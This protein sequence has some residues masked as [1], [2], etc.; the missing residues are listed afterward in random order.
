MRS[1]AARSPPEIFCPSCDGVPLGNQVRKEVPTAP[2]S[3][4]SQVLE[5]PTVRT[6]SA[7]SG[8]RRSCAS[9]PPTDVSEEPQNADGQGLLPLPTEETLQRRAQSDRA[10]TEIAK[11]LLRGYA[12][13]AEECPNLTCFSVPLVRPPKT[14]DGAPSPNRECVV[15]RSVFTFGPDGSLV[16]VVTHRVSEIRANAQLPVPTLDSTI[17]P[18]SRPAEKWMPPHASRVT[19][20]STEPSMPSIAHSTLPPSDSLNKTVATLELSLTALASRL[21]ELSSPASSVRGGLNTTAILEVSRAMES[22]LSALDKA[23]QMSQT[24]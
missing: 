9:T 23:K 4:G 10:S 13:L 19:C 20:K 22:V 11:L 16:P 12:M 2:R 6:E 24:Y 15:C 1:P 14:S 21:H 5:A 18:A 17:P 3:I 8:S 7:S